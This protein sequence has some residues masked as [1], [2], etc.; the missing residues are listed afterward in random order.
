MLITVGCSTPKKEPEAELIHAP[1]ISNSWKLISPKTKENCSLTLSFSDMNKMEMNYLGSSYEGFYEIDSVL[2]NYITINI[3]KKLGWDES[4]H[5]NP[6][7]LSLYEED[8]QFSYEIVY[9]YLYFRKNEKVIIFQQDS[10]IV[11]D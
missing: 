8:T 11:T 4:C 7:Y 10:T 2:T 6:E 3:F 1:L 9:D 5:I